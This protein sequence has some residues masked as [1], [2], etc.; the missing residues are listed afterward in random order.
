MS[1]KRVYDTPWGRRELAVGDAEQIRAN[2]GAEFAVETD[3]PAETSL[4]AEI[5]A[6]KAAGI[7]F[8]PTEAP[9]PAE[10]AN[11][12]GTGTAGASKRGRG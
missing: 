4:E 12:G 7:E 1:D 5:A 6:A 10:D 11:T 2:Y 8:E 3:Q 9:A